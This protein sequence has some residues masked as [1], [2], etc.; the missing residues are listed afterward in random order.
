[1]W[2]QCFFQSGSLK[3]GDKFTYLGSNVSSTEHDIN[4][5]LANTWTAIERISVIW[6]SDL[7]DKIKRNFFTKSDRINTAILM[8]H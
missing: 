4:T 6:K 3:L 5:R 2:R 1:M 8:Y 7:S